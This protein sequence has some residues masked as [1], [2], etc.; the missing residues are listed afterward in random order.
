M[1]VAYQLV[2]RPNPKD[3]LA[4]K[5]YYASVKASGTTE[6][7]SLCTTISDRGTC[8]KGDIQAAIDGLIFSMKQGLA[9]GRIIQLGEFG[10]F[11]MS[12]G[13]T[14]VE[15]SKEYAVSMILRKKIIFTPGKL[16]KDMMKTIA[17][18]SAGVK[19]AEV[20]TEP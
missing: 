14:G 11:R 7:E 8:I 17:F 6:F 15:D 9:E 4:P 16:L 3:K 12:V 20:V 2:L 13:G 19:P 18:R 5:K 10:N 1:S